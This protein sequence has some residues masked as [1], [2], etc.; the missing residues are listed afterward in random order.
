MM[1]IPSDIAYLKIN[2][3]HYSDFVS[4]QLLTYFRTEMQDVCPCW[5]LVDNTNAFDSSDSRQSSRL[6]SGRGRTP[7]ETPGND[8]LRDPEER[9]IQGRRRLASGVNP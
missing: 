7:G 8:L 5:M 2:P 9:Q 1:G 4:D 3:A 6:D